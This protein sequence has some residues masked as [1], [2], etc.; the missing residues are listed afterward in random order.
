MRISATLLSVI[1]IVL[2][3]NA[4][5][6]ELG[7]ADFKPSPD[8]PV[9]WR[10]DWTGH[11]PGAT[12]PLQ[13]NRHV[14]GI[15]SELKYQA[16]KPAGEPGKDAA[17][18]EYFT[19]KDWLVVGPFDGA[20]MEKDHLGG[21]ANIS[22]NEGDKA[23]AATWKTLHVSMDNQTTHIH[24]GGMC[25]H[26]NIDFTYAFGKFS[27][28]KSSNFVVEGDLAN[29]TAYAHTY[30]HSPASGKVNLI[31]LNWGSGAKAWLNGK[32]LA[33]V[34]ETNQNVWNKKEIEVTLNPGW[35]RLLIKVASGEIAY[36][37]GNEAISRWR[38]VAYLTPVGPV[39][40]ETQNVAWM[41]RVTGRSM[42]QPVVV[43]DK[44]YFGSNISD[45][46]CVN[47]A[48]GKV[49]WIHSNTPWDA[50]TAEE[51]A[52]FKDKIEPLVTQLEKMNEEV[53]AAINA[54][55]SPQGMNSDQ[56]AAMDKKLKDKNDLEN[57][58]HKEFETI[59]KKR[60]PPLT[61]NE[62]A[63]SNAAPCTDGSRIYWACGGGMKGVGA[64]VICCYDPA[65]KR[66]WS[67][68]EPLGA[69]EHG[70]HTSPFLADGKLIYGA[71]RW[72][73]G[74][75][76]ATGKQL[77]KQKCEEFCGASPE[78]V[79]LGGE[80]AILSKPT[81]RL[82][83]LAHVSDGAKFTAFDCG[84]FGDSTPIVDNGVIYVTDKF[85]G[86]TSA[87]VA[88]TALQL[89]DHAA[90]KAPV[91]QLYELNWEANHVQTRGISYWVASPL[92]L[93]GLV[94]TLD[95]S[96]GLMIVDTKAQKT[97]YRGWLDWYC[98][99]NRYLYGAVASPT[100]GGKNIYLVDNSGYTIII[101]P[102]PTYQEVA[103]NVL[104]NISPSSHSGN[105]CHVEA[106]YTNPVFCGDTIYL[107]GEE[108]L[109]AI[110]AK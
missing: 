69:A 18:L 87:N 15:T 102:G 49:A 7:S 19:V 25:G 58:I 22:P 79:K 75:D 37:E 80:T 33:V 100:L 3:S 28:D 4:R 42:S 13:W 63:S 68:H 61:G 34:V 51:K 5:A 17:A 6:Q 55:V 35:N 47:K 29:K 44:L 14:K 39:S 31:N 12:P 9:G 84:T 90:D 86:W 77:W 105:P 21:E 30:I 67:Y 52:Q 107:K 53:A 101:K 2:L 103:R 10:G 65:G 62:V 88:F 46:I 20:D 59:D 74:F 43:G 108:Y 81:G 104:E 73:L 78:P 26:L 98:R 54:Q 48:D 24:N 96:G 97:T 64:S 99:Y 94:Y 106:F 85:K 40:Y 83:T 82:I 50:L 23:G 92:C 93:D 60:F 56:Q 76:A 57:K 89:P 71:A 27:R 95:M 110:K 91:K 16:K 32:P 109:Y 11:Y 1:L 72:L 41:T 70:L 45:L 38:S 66:L 8:R 36:K